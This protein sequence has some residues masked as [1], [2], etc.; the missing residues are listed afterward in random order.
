[1]H[2]L[3]P[4]FLWAFALLGI[5]ILIHLFYFRRYKKVFFT[6]V[7]FLQ[8]LVEETATR[9]KIKDFLILLCRLLAVACMVLA[10]AQP[11]MK[12]DASSRN[13]KNLSIFI[14]NSW[15]MEAETNDG[16]LLQ[17]A[18]QLG[19]ELI[20]AHADNDRFQILTN[21][22][23]GK[24]QRIVTK[25]DAQLLLEEIKT[26]PASQNLSRIIS[27]QIQCFKNA[28]IQEAE[29]YIISDF[30]KSMC[31][32]DTAL[33]EDGFRLIFVPV[34]SIHENN[35]SIDSAYFLSPVFLPGLQNQI[36]FQVSNRGAN[37]IDELRTSLNLNGQ[38]YPG[39]TL[40]LEP[41]EQKTDTIAVN[42]LKSG[43]QKISLGIKDYPVQFDDKYYM[44]CATDTTYKIL[45]IYQD[46]IPLALQNAIRSIP[47]FEFS[48]TSYQRVNF[49]E[50]GDQK[51]IV[52]CDLK[53]ISSGLA[54]ELMKAMENGVQL[55]VFPGET[56]VPGAYKTLHDQLQL[57]SLE[58]Y[59]QSNQ[60]VGKINTESDVYKDVFTKI[61]NN[62]KLP[63][64]R[65]RYRLSGGLPPDM[66]L[67]YRDGSPYLS[68]YKVQNAFA[69]LCASPFDPKINDLSKNAEIFIPLL[70]KVALNEDRRMVYAYDLGRDPV[71]SWPFEP[72]SNR[73]DLTLVMSGPEELIP[74][75]RFMGN[76]ILLEFY[77]QVK[78]S[79]IYELKNKSQLLGC[80]AFNDARIESDLSA[81]TSAELQAKFGTLVNV[82]DPG[83]NGNFYNQ[84][85]TEQAGHAIW[86]WMIL[87]AALFV[88]AESLLLR[89]WK[90]N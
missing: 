31:Q 49:N 45:A 32:L 40:K 22:F 14:D 1:M 29:L 54:Q 9:N 23:E 4:G 47:Y 30:Q 37:Q 8:E 76:K 13:L 26:G 71:V 65:G 50:F 73:Q 53:E 28:G 35:I 77:D 90:S 15:S 48:A 74:S 12:N 81:F 63:E 84:I 87:A 69:Y 62:I 61:S 19:K 85:K 80:I 68:R 38:E 5:P 88:F 59:D 51:L 3:F 21:D 82:L 11:V 33:L 17:N 89:F 57:P 39:P 27:R 41:G 42:L 78:K 2:F 75:S 66:I 83:A 18:M 46:Q 86:W 55:F 20:D 44:T 25:A 43:W 7:H 64:T 16:K 56:T 60:Q 52:L 24:H 10:F 6:N 34:Q 79:G 72:T 70:F 67:T 36:V 58:S